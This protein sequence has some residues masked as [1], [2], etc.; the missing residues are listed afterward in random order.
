MAPE[1]S[2][3]AFLFEVGWI[4]IFFC[5]SWWRVYESLTDS[6]D[7][8][9]KGGSNKTKC[10]KFLQHDSMHKLPGPTIA[11]GKTKPGG[12]FRKNEGKFPKYFWRNSTPM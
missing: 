5:F 8:V 6:Y 2:A 10:H 1:F 4:E 12:G 3:V 9:G 11:V 7:M